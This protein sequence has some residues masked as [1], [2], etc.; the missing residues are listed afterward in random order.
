[1]PAIQLISFLVAGIAISAPDPTRL[2]RDW[3][4]ATIYPWWAALYVV[5]GVVSSIVSILLRDESCTP[6]LP[7]VLV[8]MAAQVA[9]LGLV[10]VEHLEAFVRNGRRLCG[11]A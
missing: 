1:M 4:G 6:V 2:V 5:V 11:A 3:S 10:A 7:T 9:G 8:V